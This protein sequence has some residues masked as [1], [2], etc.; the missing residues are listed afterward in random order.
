MNT[1][2]PSKSRERLRERFRKM[3]LCGAAALDLCQLACGRVD[4]FY[5]S[6]IHLWDVAAGEFLVRR[7][8]GLCQNLA[9]LNA[10]K[11]RYLATNGVIHDELIELLS[12]FEIWISGQ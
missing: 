3:R 2:S 6:G 11:C 5:E 4:G 1:L 7:A 12:Q 8:G 10:V 9:Q